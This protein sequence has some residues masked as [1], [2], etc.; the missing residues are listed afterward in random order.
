MHQHPDVSIV[1]FTSGRIQIVRSSR[2]RADTQ[3]KFHPAFLRLSAM[4]SLHFTG[5]GAA[6]LS[7]PH[8]I[9]QF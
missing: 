7:R 5:V 1:F 3:P 8:I 9:S 4:I 6:I 2:S